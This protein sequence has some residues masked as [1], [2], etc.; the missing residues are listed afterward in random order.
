VRDLFEKEGVFRQATIVPAGEDDIGFQARA[1]ICAFFDECLAMRLDR[2]DDKIADAA[3]NRFPTLAQQLRDVLMRLTRL[4]STPVPG[5]FDKLAKALEACLGRIRETQP[6]VAQIKKHLDTLRDGVELLQ[7]YDADL[8]D[9]VIVQVNRARNA[10]IFEAAQLRELGVLATNVD[11]SAARVK[12]HVESERPWRDIAALD[13]DVQEIRAAYV[14]ERGA[15]LQ[16]QES[17]TEK[18]RGRVRAR[19]GFSTLTADQAHRVLRPLAQAVTETDADA[20]APPLKELGDPF[21][22]RLHRAEA[23][24]NEILDQILSAGNQALITTVDLGLRNRELTNE[25]E[26]KALVNEIE[27]RLLE[28]VRAGRRVR[29]L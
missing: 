20:V 25:P 19:Q 7:R 14:A 13:E 11:A 18:A 23:A 10:L 8:T 9:A 26:V 27:A 21:G 22:V 2:A 6:T 3:A 16:Q 29:L 15:L 5:V 24:A 4:P 17:L 1:R 28:Q 12:T